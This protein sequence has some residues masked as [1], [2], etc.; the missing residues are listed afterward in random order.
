MSVRIPPYF[1]R[2]VLLI[3]LGFTPRLLTESLA[4]LAI[5]SPGEM[6][7]EIHVLTT[8]VGLAYARKEL[9]GKDNILSRFCRDYSVPELALPD[10]NIHVIEDSSGK[11]V[12]DIRTVEDNDSAADYIVALIRD[13]CADEACSLHVSIAGGRK[14]MGLLIGTAMSFFGRDQDRISHVLARESFEAGCQPYPSREELA[15]DPAILSLGEIPF[16][17]LRPLIPTPLL[18]SRYSYTEIIEASQRELNPTASVGIIRTK[19]KWKLL[20]GDAMMSPEPKHS[21]L[22]AWLAVRTKFGRATTL[23]AVGLRASSLYLMR[24]QFVAFLALF[25]T[26]GTQEK[27]FETFIGLPPVRVR[28]IEAQLQGRS[29]PTL[30]AWYEA[31]KSALT[32][33]ERTDFLNAGKKFVSKLSSS[34]TVVNDAIEETLRESIPD[35]TMRR[36]DIYRITG[37]TVDDETTYSLSVPPENI[38]APQEFTRLLAADP[39][40]G[41][42]DWHSV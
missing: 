1:Q 41:A 25:Q 15:A 42:A 6:P 22:Y 30:A 37:T 16:L 40:L 5:T 35:I 36:I 32:Q 13:L 21:A 24:R 3:A 19:R 29:F 27:S 26:P 2:R 28:D 14:S 12:E 20:I 17:R 31:F 9:Q 38:Q 11:P 8:E 34:K 39:S 33:K 18:E 4:A 7:T 10:E 23:S